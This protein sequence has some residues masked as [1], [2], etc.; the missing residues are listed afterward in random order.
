MS[1]KMGN[2]AA[3]NC[4][5]PKNDLAGCL[6]A[7]DNRKSQFSVQV[8]VLRTALSLASRGIPVFPCKPDKSPYTTNGFYG[9]SIEPGVIEAR[10]QRY[11]DALLGV[12][13]GKPSGLA[14]LDLDITKHK[15]AREWLAANKS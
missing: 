15:E 13:T 12:P 11:P 3:A 2:P 7:S 10:R 4:G 1:S 5:A 6:I 9:A 14:V 8:P